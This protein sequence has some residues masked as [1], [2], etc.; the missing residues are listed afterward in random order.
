M[1]CK[2]RGMEEEDWII[3]LSVIKHRNPLLWQ[4]TVDLYACKSIKCKLV[5]FEECIRKPLAPLFNVTRDI[6]RRLNLVHE[7]NV[8]LIHKERKKLDSIAVDRIKCLRNFSSGL[9]KQNVT[10]YV[11]P[12]YDLLLFLLSTSNLKVCLTID[13]ESCYKYLEASQNLFLSFCC[14]QVHSV[15]DAKYV[16][17]LL[18]DTLIMSFLK[19]SLDEKYIQDKMEQL[20]PFVKN[21]K[22]LFDINWKVYFTLHFQFFPNFLNLKLKMCQGAEDLNEVKELLHIVENI[23]F[24][25]ESLLHFSHAMDKEQVKCNNLKDQRSKAYVEIFLNRSTSMPQKYINQFKS[26]SS[27]LEHI[28]EKRNTRHAL[29]CLLQVLNKIN[30]SLFEKFIS[31]SLLNTKKIITARIYIQAALLVIG[32]MNLVAQF[33]LLK[34]P[35]W[36]FELQ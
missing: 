16:N 34:W 33:R 25:I 1:H 13:F 35:R 20:G 31:S 6:A 17:R 23:C 29:Q 8:S 11:L 14:F 10:R 3:C 5:D 21:K 24:L 28:P 19:K 27:T 4:R 12:K 7:F 2:S 32:D 18:F 26:K 9:N 30:W 36:A 15:D 22:T